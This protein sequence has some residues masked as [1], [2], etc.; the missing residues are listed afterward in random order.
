VNDVPDAIVVRSGLPADHEACVALWVAACAARDGWAL[1][2]VA[3]RARPKFDKKCRLVVA[4]RRDSCLAGFALA[5]TAGSGITTDPADAVVLALLA[6]D[7]HQQGSGLGRWLLSA[8]TESLTESGFEQIVLHALADNRVA[9]RLYEST[10]WASYGPTFEHALL[11]RPMQTYRHLLP[12][13][14]I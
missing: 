10:G 13:K 3:E 14:M 5:T 4:E 6:V 8:I 9:V 7:P 11:K 1:P 2:G 12:Q